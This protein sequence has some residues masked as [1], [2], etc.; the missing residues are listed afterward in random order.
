MPTALPMRALRR[1]AT[2]RPE[3]VGRARANGGLRRSGRALAVVGWWYRSLAGPRDLDLQGR[4]CELDSTS[5]L[6]RNNNAWGS[7]RF[8]RLFDVTLLVQINSSTCHVQSLP[9][10]WSIESG[11]FPHVTLAESSKAESHNRRF[12]VDFLTG[13]RKGC[14]IRF[15]LTTCHCS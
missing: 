11:S 1:A 5:P 3:R 15:Q 2:S 6:R 13:S 14:D 4:E 7:P 8:L 12:V 9:A 10:S